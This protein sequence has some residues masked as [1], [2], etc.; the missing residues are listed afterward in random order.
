M[1]A[2]NAKLPD[3]P[4][5]PLTFPGDNNKLLF[6]Q[7]QAAQQSCAA[8]EQVLGEAETKLRLGGKA[9]GQLEEL[10]WLAAYDLA[11]GR[12]LALRVRAGEY[13]LRVAEKKQSLQAQANQTWRLV[14][15]AQLSGGEKAT[16]L[17]AEG[18][19]LLQR[20]LAEHPKTPWATLAQREL[21]QASGWEWKAV[22]AGN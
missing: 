2:S 12:V 5:P 3:L 11:L 18:T 21:S 1:L 9:R 6:Q 7:L 16:A 19:A 20:V 13:N 17:S 15:S 10:R 8:L 4:L 22:A 14:P